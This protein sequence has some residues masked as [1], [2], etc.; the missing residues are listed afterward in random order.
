MRRLL[1]LLLAG[2]AGCGGAPTSAPSGTFTEKAAAP[3]A[4]PVEVACS[5][6]HGKKAATPLSRQG[7]PVALVKGEKALFAYVADAD[8]N[9]IHTVDVDAGKQLSSAPLDGSPREVLALADG[10]VLVTL[11][12]VSRVVVLEPEA[13]VGSKLVATCS[14]EVPAEPWGIAANADESTVAV[15]SA[16][17]ATLSTFDGRDLHPRGSLEISRD[18]R[19]VLFDDEGRVWI[20]HLVGGRVSVLDL[21]LGLGQAKSIDVGSFKSAPGIADAD[22]LARRTGGQG[23]ALASIV[24]KPVRQEGFS[25]IQGEP[26]KPA[27]SKPARRILVPMVSVD[28]G[29]PSRSTSVYYGPPFD[30]IP[31]QTPRVTAIDP[32]LDRPLS[33]YL[34]GTDRRLFARE[35]VLPRAAAVRASTGSLFVACMGID[36]VLELDA[37]ALEPF[38]VERRRIEVPSGP[39]GIAIDDASA[40]AVVF[41][42]FDGRLT[43]LDLGAKSAAN[44]TIELAYAPKGDLARVAA[45]RALFYRTD[46]VRISNDGIACASCHPDGRDDAITWATPEGPRQTLALA[47]R[48][49]DTAPYGWVGHKGTIDVYIGNTVSRLGG[50]GIDEAAIKDLS[51]FVQVVAPPPAA[52]EMNDLSRRGREIFFSDEQRCAVCHMGADRTDGL[53]HDFTADVFSP[54]VRF[55]T[56]S[57]RRLSGSGPYFHD[58]RYETLEA[59]LNDPSSK[60]G[61]SHKLD[62]GDRKALA[63]FLRTL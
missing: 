30:G 8:S 46:D 21:K 1:A 52:S 36:A 26:P 41:S 23:Y 57:L 39:T 22:R 4:R 47:G 44:K 10:R 25:G 51:Q 45:G 6:K 56:P 42:Q 14:R 13:E 58:G 5:P 53:L 61:K 3:A 48:L 31:K 28:P 62:E 18:P 49:K 33:S 43:V 55:E 24:E 20:S 11:A 54:S 63:A 29:D 27:P 9:V 59:L 17:A 60:M 50:Q 2:A 12:D 19:S 37:W 35:C 40:R 15:T 7:S 32:D 16:Y 38:R 34:L